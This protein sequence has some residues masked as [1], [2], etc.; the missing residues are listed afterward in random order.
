[1]FGVIWFV[2][3]VQYPGFAHVDAASFPAFHAHHTRQITLVVGPLMLVE[4]VAMIWVSTALVQVPA[5]G[6]LA[7]S[8]DV[9]TWQHLVRTNW[10]RTI[11]WT[12]RAALLGWVVTR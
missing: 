3:L 5:H 2:Q 12:A 11:A 7:E 8:F 1:M 9:S 4:L 6:R 10:L